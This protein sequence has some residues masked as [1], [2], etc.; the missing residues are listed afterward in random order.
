M[1][2]HL[3]LTSVLDGGGWS[4]SLSGPLTPVVSDIAYRLDDPGS[5]TCRSRYF[6]VP[7]NIQTGSGTHLTSY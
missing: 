3:F 5:V 7:I 4:A 1:E 2:L 6:S